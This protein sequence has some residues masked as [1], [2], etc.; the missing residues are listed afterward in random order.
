M[1]NQRSIFNRLL[2]L[3]KHAQHKTPVE[4]FTTEIFAGI[5]NREP[6]VLNDFATSVLKIE[7]SKYNISSQKTYILPD[8]I[9]CRVDMVLESDETLCFVENK[10]ESSEGEQQLLRYSQALSKYG[11]GKNTYQRYCT[12]YYDPKDLT[13]H[14]FVQFRWADVANILKKYKDNP[15]IE[16]FYLF[17]EEKNM[18]EEL[19]LNSKTL[20][21]ME[22]FLNI[23]DTIRILLDR[24]KHIFEMKFEK[25][26]SL[27]IDTSSADGYKIVRKKNVFG[28][29]YSSI[30]AGF[31][32]NDEPRAILWIYSADPNSSLYTL[33]SKLKDET[34]MIQDNNGPAY[35][36]YEK[37]LKDFLSEK[38][39]IEALE[40]WYDKHFDLL[41]EFI[42]ETAELEWRIY[43]IMNI[44]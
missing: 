9:D 33:K 7:A 3:Y 22:E 1:K 38:S 35:P 11:N 36:R 6:E 13:E 19:N 15:L 41:I 44:S 16:E 23:E 12:K 27:G 18:A 10:V 29:K 24:I 14:Q 43:P 21:L 20:F 8:N 30:G 40:K 42:N 31:D 4:D 5:L 2:K 39:P 37:Y 26:D 17:L 28:E 25:I 34:Y 32:F